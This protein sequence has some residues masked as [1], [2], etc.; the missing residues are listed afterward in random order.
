MSLNYLDD[1]ILDEEILNNENKNQNI[2]SC[3]ILKDDFHKYKL[4]FPLLEIHDTP[5]FL[6]FKVKDQQILQNFLN[7]NYN[8]ED[9]KV[10][11]IVGSR[12]NSTYGKEAMKYLLKSLA[13]Q[14]IIIVS[15]LALGIDT[16][17]HKYAIENEFKTISIPGSGL[18]KKIIYPSINVKLAEEILNTGNVLMSE[19]EDDQK[20]QLYY[21]PARNRIMAA[22]SDAVLIIEAGERS[23]TLITARLA[24]EYN[25]NVGVIP[26]TIFAEGGVGSNKLIQD[27]AT[28]I[29]NERDLLELLNINI[30]NQS[31]L[32]L[33][34]NNKEN[35]NKFE[36]AMSSLS[37]NE[38]SILEKIIQESNIEK[39]VLLSEIEEEFNISYTDILVA[40]MSLEINGFIKEEMGEVRILK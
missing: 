29:L 10:L 9:Y 5:Q 24:M 38:R 36:K 18:G 8:G 39:D 16:L 4:L 23:G 33:D 21:F 32:D 37:I 11:T 25:K 12:K 19:Y 34:F 26:N 27:G 35:R 30:D 6:N 20:S 3:K 13:G 15:G 17:A 7:K 40:L 22:I 31:I 1:E 2:F 14:N 28:P